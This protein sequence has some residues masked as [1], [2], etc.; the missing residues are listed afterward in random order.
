MATKTITINGVGFAATVEVEDGESYGDAFKKAGLA[1][2]GDFD[3]TAAG[4]SVEPTDTAEDSVTA[5]PKS[6]SL[7]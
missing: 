2:A 1:D 3:I 7:G 6:A 4:E 5:S